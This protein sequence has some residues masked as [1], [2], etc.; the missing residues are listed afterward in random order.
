LAAAGGVGG[1]GPTEEALRTFLAL[2]IAFMTMF[3]GE[4]HAKFL[5]GDT[6]RGWCFSEDIGDQEA[7]LGYVLGVADVLSSENRGELTQYRACI[8]QI[9]ATDAVNTAKDYLN[10]HRQAGNVTA[11]DLVAMALSEAFPCP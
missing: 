7:C 6:L 11:S 1:S 4:A 10:V 5:D 3:M 9:D 2:A 8:P